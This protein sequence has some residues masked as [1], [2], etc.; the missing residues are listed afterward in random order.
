MAEARQTKV[1]NEAK[2][3][4]GST[5]WAK[6][7]ERKSDVG[8]FAKDEWKCNLF[9]AEM[10]HAGGI[11]VPLINYQPDG[12]FVWILVRILQVKPPA[13]NRPPCAIDWYN[14]KDRSDLSFVTFVGEGTQ[15]LNAS[16]PGDIVTDGHHCGLISAPRKTISA[17]QTE[18]VENDWG[19]RKDQLSGASAVR[20]YRYHP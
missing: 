7:V 4:I 16:W 15:G 13:N 2:K 12:V 10:M 17:T 6:D 20:I 14:A 1:M 11:A 9:I 19:W 5:A 3:R 8:D 18:I